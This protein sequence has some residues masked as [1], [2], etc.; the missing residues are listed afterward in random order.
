MRAWCHLWFAILLGGCGR[1]TPDQSD[2]PGVDEQA[3]PVSVA[4]PDLPTAV[5]CVDEPGMI[6][7]GGGEHFDRNT[8]KTVQLRG[9]WIDRTEVTIAAYRK[10]VADG[11][12][13]PYTDKST[14]TWNAPDNDDL[15]VNCIDWYQ[16]FKFCD[17]SHKRL[18]TT[19]EWGWAAQGREEQ[20]HYPWGSGAP[21]SCDLSIVDM[22]DT[23][24]VTG[25]GRGRAWPVGSRPA[26]VTRDGVLDM[27]GNVAEKTSTGYSDDPK[28]TR[29]QMG[30]NWAN[31][32]SPRPI[33]EMSYMMVYEAQ[34]DKGAAPFG[35]RKV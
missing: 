4:V 29:Y 3:A 23:D 17:W 10:F 22:D 9:F 25:C 32:P 8:E 5:D 20:R 28:S 26:D 31:R 19:S 18:P 35:Q 27:F 16:A 2:S 1:G 14:C 15:P 34:S 6:Y 7:I 33:A 13:T 30:S 12:D 11:F 24:E 21:P